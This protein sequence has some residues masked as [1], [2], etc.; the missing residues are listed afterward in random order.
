V[1]EPGSDRVRRW[2]RS[3]DAATSRLSEV[4]IASALM[5]RWREGAFDQV[6]RDRALFAVAEDLDAL[7]VVEMVPAIAARARDLQKAHA[8]RAGDAIH[9]ASCLELRAKLGDQI[10]FAA[11]DARL[12]RAARAEGLKAAR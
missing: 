6:D 11:F 10:T 8:L 2:L 5:R 9:L 12:N 1:R 7:S 4:E 3:G